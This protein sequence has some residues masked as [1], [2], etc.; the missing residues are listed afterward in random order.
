MLEMIFNVAS[1]NN[2]SFNKNNNFFDVLYETGLSKSIFNELNKHLLSKKIEF[3]D[4]FNKEKKDDDKSIL[5]SNFVINNLLNFLSVKDVGC[6][7]KDV[8]NIE[9]D[10]IQKKRIDKDQNTPSNSIDSLKNRKNDNIKKNKKK[11]EVLKID[12]SPNKLIKNK[13]TYNHI[14][15]L[16]N[17]NIRNNVY[18]KKINHKFFQKKISMS[19]IN[20]NNIKCVEDAKKI[21]VPTDI[22]KNKNV[23]FTSKYENVINRGSSLKV[24]NQ[25]KDM[26]L[27][28]EPLF[29]NDSSNSIKWKKLISQKIL[30]SISNKFN[31]VE[32][33]LKPEYLGSIH[34]VINMKNNAATLKLISKYNEV[35][36]FL[37]DYM[38]FL[39]DSL[40]KNGIKLEEFKI[41]SSLK[42]NKLKIY[43]NSFYKNMHRTDNFKKMLNIYEKKTDFTKYK[44]IDICV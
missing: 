42:N 1:Q 2:A 12:S 44:L 3:D 5:C 40:T 25:P 29:S 16:N 39:R 20:K 21:I 8:N 18:S 22:K 41:C 6:N 15:E 11:I 24:F 34:V 38:P 43:K 33:H 30:L 31:E 13:N 23:L 19:N 28:I 4:V 35:R 7:L 9:D 32:I 37:D 36:M 27:C 17:I 10:K 14:R 26:K